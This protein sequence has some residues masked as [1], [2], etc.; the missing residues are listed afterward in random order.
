M[1]DIDQAAPLTEGYQ[2]AANGPDPSP[3][4]GGS[5]ARRASAEAAGAQNAPEAPEPVETETP[6]QAPRKLGDVA[7]FVERWFADH[8]P[9]SAVARDT[10][11]W[12]VAHAAMQDLKRR[13]GALE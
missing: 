8:F 9:G 2:P 1:T 11:A 10:R 3:P 13:L 12:N 4:S 6:H 5:S 7:V